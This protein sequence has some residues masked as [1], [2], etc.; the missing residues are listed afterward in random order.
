MKTLPPPPDNE[1]PLM[2][3]RP[4]PFPPPEIMGVLFLFLVGAIIQ[5]IGLHGLK[6]HVSCH[7]STVYCSP[8]PKWPLKLSRLKKQGGIR[9]HPREDAA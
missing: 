9:L 6:E 7:R 2:V 1:L 3:S 4:L 8:Y 5:G